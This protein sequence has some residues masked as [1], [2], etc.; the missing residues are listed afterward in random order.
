MKKD[1]WFNT[2]INRKSVFLIGQVPTKI[3]VE[4][5]V[6]AIQHTGNRKSFIEV[7]PHPCVYLETGLNRSTS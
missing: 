2:R 6:F 4:N 5:T 7:L 1:R 3:W